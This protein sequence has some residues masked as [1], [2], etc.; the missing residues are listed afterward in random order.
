MKC[1]RGS[2]LRCS[3][4]RAAN[5]R[6]QHFPPVSAGGSRLRRCLSRGPRCS[7]STSPRTILMPRA[8][9]S[10]RAP[11]ASGRGRCSWRATTARSSR[12]LPRQSTT[13]T[14]PRGKRSHWPRD[15]S[16]TGCIAPRARIRCS[17]R[18]STRPERRMRRFTRR[19]KAKSER[20]AS[21][22]TRRGRSRAEGC[23]SQR[24]A[25]WQRSSLPIARKPLQLGARA[26]TTKSLRRLRSE[27][28][29]GPA[30]ARAER[31]WPCPFHA[32]CRR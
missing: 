3:R 28:C 11:C 1:L 25:V 8:W 9:P 22:G 26:T 4:V 15:T 10:L 30:R 18:R 20:L 6:W 13:S 5:V 7:F 27:R 12:K 17:L 24:R 29:V 32:R 14:L 21:T 23:V 2:A 19:S 16:F 31:R